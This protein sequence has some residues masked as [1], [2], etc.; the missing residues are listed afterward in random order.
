MKSGEVVST[1]LPVPLVVALD[2][3][4]AVERR[5]RSNMLAC[6]V[7]RGLVELGDEAKETP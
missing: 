7:A 4:A 6:L 2:R 5:T 1:R 3:Q